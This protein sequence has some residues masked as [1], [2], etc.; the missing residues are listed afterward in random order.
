MEVINITRLGAL[1]ALVKVFTS[2][3]FDFYVRELALD[4]GQQFGTTDTTKFGH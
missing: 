4:T 3:T 1:G 2:R